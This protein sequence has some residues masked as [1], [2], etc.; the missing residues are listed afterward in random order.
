MNLTILYRG[1][2]ISCNYGCE[3]C[4]FAKRSQ[5]AVE[6]ASDRQ[7]LERFTD[8]IA[9]NTQHQF[10]ILFTPWGEALIHPWYQQAL[11]KLTHLPNVN[12]AA[13]QTNLS[14]KLDWVDDC[15][16]ERLAL[17]ATF[18]PEWV[19]LEQFLAQCWELDR[20]RVRFSAG[21]VGF[22]KFKNAI[23]S[24]RRQLPSHIYLWINA[25]KRALSQLSEADRQFFD[26]ID[27]L[28]HLN[29]HYYPSYGKTCRA[30][31]SVISVDGDGTVRRCHFIKEPI[32]NI[33]DPKFEATL[34]K[35]LCTN[36]TCHCH[37]GYVHLDYLELD[38]VFGSGILER[39]PETV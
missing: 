18:H 19:S 24:L 15:N 2:L 33:Y 23:A 6:L 20:R 16:K 4:P 9:Q 27:P 7:S 34:F 13:I 10:S 1:S 21:V 22:P 28:Y 3:Y 14:C 17:W 39:I 32:G 25:V 36:E 30:G 5:S 11:A 29:T 38:K 12:K 35:R 8:W 31:E 26:S 37:I